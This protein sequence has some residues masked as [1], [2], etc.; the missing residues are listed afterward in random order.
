MAVSLCDSQKAYS[1]CP[2]GQATICVHTWMTDEMECSILRTGEQLEYVALKGGICLREQIALETGESVENKINELINEYEPKWVGQRVQFERQT[3]V[4]EW[5]AANKKVRLLRK[6]NDVLWQVFDQ[7]AQM[8][9]YLSHKFVLLYDQGHCSRIHAH[10]FP[11]RIQYDKNFYPEDDDYCP[12][13]A[14]LDSP[15]NTIGTKQRMTYFEYC[16]VIDIKGVSARQ[17]FIYLKHVFSESIFDFNLIIDKNNWAISIVQEEEGSPIAIVIEGINERA[18]RY[19]YY[20]AMSKTHEMQLIVGESAEEKIKKGFEE[21]KSFPMSRSKLEKLLQQ[22]K[23]Q[24]EVPKLQIFASYEK[25]VE[26]L[27]GCHPQSLISLLLDLDH[28]EIT[29]HPTPYRRVKLTNN[30]DQTWVESNLWLGTVDDHELTLSFAAREKE[31]GTWVEV[32]RPLQYQTWARYHLE[33]IG[34]YLRSSNPSDSSDKELVTVDQFYLKKSWKNKEKIL[35][36][37]EVWSNAYKWLQTNN[38]QPTLTASQKIAASSKSEILCT[39]KDNPVPLLSLLPNTTNVHI[40]LWLASIYE[41]PGISLEITPLMHRFT[42]QQLSDEEGRSA[43]H[44]AC[45]KGYIRE[46]TV[47]IQHGPYYYQNSNDGKGLSVLDVVLMEI[48]DGAQQLDF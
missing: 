11:I 47:I 2:W 10:F 34:I 24:A 25:M 44:H 42:Q 22:M 4:H 17:Y 9:R 8:T 21:S 37:K 28:P 43:L 31:D 46:A 23:A 14:L 18:E 35:A 48:T 15:L 41:T 19:T 32:A 36:P 39:L 26:S 29:A 27:L 30:K 20:A 1:H 7:H 13:V 12:A 16:H 3:V 6:A 40:F 5:S 38:L 45:A 33:S